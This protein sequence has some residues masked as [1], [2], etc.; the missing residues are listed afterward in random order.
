MKFPIFRLLSGELSFVKRKVITLSINIK[1]LLS[2]LSAKN[3]P[4]ITCDKTL[5]LSPIDCSC[6]CNIKCQPGELYNYE[7]CECTWFPTVKIIY[8]AQKTIKEFYKR[9]AFENTNTTRVTEFLDKTYEIDI[10]ISDFLEDE[11]N[12]FSTKNLTETMEKFTKYSNIV[13]NVKKEFEEY[14]TISHVRCSTICDDPES[15]Q[16]NDCICYLTPETDSYTE[17]LYKFIDIEKEIRYY[18]GGGRPQELEGFRS[19]TIALRYIFQQ[20]YKYFVENNGKY[21]PN[22]VKDFIQRISAETE[23]IRT[24]FEDWKNRSNQPIICELGTCSATQVA[25]LKI[26]A[27][28]TIR[29]YDKLQGILDNRQTLLSQ[30]DG[31]NI[32]SVNKEIMIANM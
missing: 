6:S 3:C 16:A 21:D 23:S 17:A 11:E 8:D 1:L 2:S 22:F 4:G 7:N 15:I 18:N 28:V 30:L 13:E 32:D 10:S 19:R 20:L 24:D 25:D 9:A 14:V 29:D 26:C 5:Q 27:C 12:N 31:L